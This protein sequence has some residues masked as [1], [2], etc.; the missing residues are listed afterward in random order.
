MNKVQQNFGRRTKS[1]A[2]RHAARKRTDHSIQFAAASASRR[3]FRWR[4]RR[5]TA[6][7]DSFPR[8]ER[9]TARF[10]SKLMLTFAPVFVATGWASWVHVHDA[11][12]DT[13]EKR[14]DQA[15]PSNGSGRV[16]SISFSVGPTLS[17]PSPH[18][19]KNPSEIRYSRTKTSVAVLNVTDILPCSLE[20]SSRYQRVKL[21]VG[22]LSNGPMTF[23]GPVE[24]ISSKVGA[25]NAVPA[26]ISTLSLRSPEKSERECNERKLNFISQ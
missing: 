15:P 5:E 24:R 25:L 11:I 20:N 1:T 21:E 4:S 14:K 3:S 19:R 18:Q 9:A 12:V 7:R 23:F 10:K 8:R 2:T 6:A 16:D 22:F 26:E 17:P 13:P